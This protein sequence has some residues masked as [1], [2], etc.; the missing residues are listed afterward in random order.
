MTTAFNILSIISSY[1]EETANIFVAQQLSATASRV[2]KQK[3]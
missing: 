1:L 3:I 2:A